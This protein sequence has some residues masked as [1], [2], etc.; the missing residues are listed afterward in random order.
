[1]KYKI[2]SG[3]SIDKPNANYLVVDQ[4]GKVVG[5]GACS[6]LGFPTKSLA[7]LWKQRLEENDKINSFFVRNGLDFASAQPVGIATKGEHQQTLIYEHHN[8]DIIIVLDFNDDNNELKMTI[9]KK[10]LYLN[11]LK[12]FPNLYQL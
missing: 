9:E 11:V 6:T 1:M 7:F 3:Q 4:T 10:C 2:V 5:N 8:Q 12:A